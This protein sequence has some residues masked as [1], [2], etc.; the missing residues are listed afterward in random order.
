MNNYLS[1]L[2]FFSL[3]LLLTGRPSDV[4]A[5][6]GALSSGC[7]QPRS[8]VFPSPTQLAASTRRGEENTYVRRVGLWTRSGNRFT[9]T[10]TVPFSWT[11]RQVLLRFA[12]APGTFRVEVNGREAGRCTD[13]NTPVEML[14]TG[15][16]SEGRNDISVLLDTPSPTAPLEAWEHD[17]GQELGPVWLL[18]QPTLRIRDLG[19]RCWQ[20]AQSGEYMAEVAVV[21]KSDALNSRTARLWYELLTPE[22]ETAVAG[23]QDLTL[24]LR[25]EDT[26]RFVAPV[27]RRWLWSA[28][29]PHLY[30]LRLK[31]QHEGRYDDYQEYRIGLREITMEQGQMYV[32]GRPATL[33]VR[34]VQPQLDPDDV[35]E[36]KS[37]GYNTLRLLPG[38]VAPALYERCD[39]VG[40]Y[41]I[42]QAPID[43][44]THGASRQVGGNPSN[45]PAWRDV[46]IERALRT[47]HTAKRH[48]SVIAFSLARHAAN[49]ICLYESYTALKQ[50]GDIRPV[51]YP[52]A[53]GEWNNDPLTVH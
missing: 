12:S 19:T 11:N 4:R 36:I 41:V 17:E 29:V 16:V 45:D 7:E 18:S 53:E 15:L 37:Q 24:D 28:E 13:G 32:N 2:V 43:T 20:V 6:E 5:Q 25:R 33:R 31:T 9:T 3:S 35:A 26:V 40:M 10:F 21:M 38:T 8:E 46:Y 1:V 34:E 48:A 44:H 14:V 22:G 49:G 39:N 51:V 27:P 52:E 23:Y 47:Y 30:T 42:A 50:L